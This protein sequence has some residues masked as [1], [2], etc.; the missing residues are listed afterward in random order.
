MK[1]TKPLKIGIAGLGTVGTGVLKILT[2]QKDL[3]SQRCQHPV[4]VVAVSAKNRSKDRGVDL[5]K[6]K[7]Y[8]NTIDIANDE[9]VDAVVE[10]IGGDT[11]IAYDLCKTA[12]SN[13]KH[14]ITANKA[15]IA[16]RGVELAKLAEKN[17][18]ALA[19]EA[20]VAGGIPVIKTLKEALAGNNITKVSGILNGTCNY[21]LTAM[22]KT[23]KSFNT[24]LKDAQDLGY[25]E[26]DPGFDID[27]IDAAHKLTILTALAF[28]TPVNFEKNYIEGIR[29]ISL[30]DIKYA[31]EL[32]YKI[33]LLGVCSSSDDG[34][35][36]RVCP[37]LISKK[38]PVA[39]VDGVNNAVY[40]EGD[41][42]G[43]LV[44]EGPGAGSG[45]TASAVL[46]DIVDVAN[47]RFS[48]AFG[49]KS[50][51]LKDKN[52]IKMDNLKGSY[53]MRIKVEDK[54]GV[55]ADITD[56]LRNE[57]IS[58]E[59]VL[60]KPVPEGGNANIVIITHSVLEKVT[61]DAVS[62]ITKIGAVLEAPNVIRVEA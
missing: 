28:G 19:F 10:L 42:V 38:H 53:Y 23:G 1:N 5:S 51:H 61:M 56:V 62:K 48:F 52:F 24:I 27:G 41:A 35:L 9:N 36:Q 54:P 2:Q 58:V 34:I 4:E 30:Q 3:I 43:K 22:K 57:G 15:L 32:G 26:A 7:W 18:V 12:L 47:N 55:L 8:D 6:I 13:K 46:S 25:A 14:F 37:C 16:K 59:A 20:S 40:I 44:L 29:K 39:K 45:P 31:D 50:E 21:I 60:Q 33:K 49:K 17:N 11:G